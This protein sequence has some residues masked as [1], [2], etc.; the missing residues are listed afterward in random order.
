MRQI[1]IGDVIAAAR[2]TLELP[3]P[4]RAGAVSKMLYRAHIADKVMKR[5]AIPH[6]AWGNGS[7][8]GAVFPKPAHPEPYLSDPAY[9]DALRST[10]EQVTAWKKRLQVPH[11]HHVR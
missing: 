9:L 4:Q 10:L 2:S 7:L 1:L 6:E 11:H 5:M 3:L 8:M